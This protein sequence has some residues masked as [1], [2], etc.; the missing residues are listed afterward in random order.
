MK[1]KKSPKS[2]KSSGVKKAPVPKPKAKKIDW[3]KYNQ[4]LKDRG[5]ITLWI[6]TETV[7]G[8]VDEPKI[9]SRGGQRVYSDVAIQCALTVR[10]VFHLAL[11]QTEGFFRSLLAETGRD[12]PTPDYT[13]LSR[14]CGQLEV[15]L[16]RSLPHEAID[17]VVD[18]TGIKVY[19]EG[20]WKVRQHGVGKRRTWLKL[21]LAI[22]IATQEAC[23]TVV[24]SASVSDGEAFGPL[25]DQIEGAIAST[26]GDG[27]YDRGGVREKIE[28]RGATPRIPPRRDARLQNAKNE[29]SL[30]RQKA[31][32][33]R[34]IA[35]CRIEE[36]RRIQTNGDLSE[37]RKL[38]KQ[39]THYHRRS[40]AETA[41]YRYKAIFG[42]AV[43]SRIFDNQ[44]KELCLNIVAMNKMTRLGIPATL[45]VNA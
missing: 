8:W 25:L 4:A 35:I 13:T 6:E 12:L 28:A 37:A 5:R 44:T 10:S 15:P 7:E 23:A 45:T 14:R 17:I 38:W 9:R 1:R 30:L 29:T 41:M 31:L 33:K 42:H 2:K 11:R 32:A 39:E 34:D 16:P 21:H 36:L 24:S 20:E 18:S 40:L 22:D 26:G 43:R 27:A 3:R 19:G